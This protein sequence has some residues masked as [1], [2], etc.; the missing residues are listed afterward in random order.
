MTDISQLPVLAQITNNY[1]DYMVDE[2]P[3]G[4]SGQAYVVLSNS[5]IDPS[6]ENIIAGPAVLEASCLRSLNSREFALM[7][8][9]CIQRKSCLLRLT[10]GVQ[11][12]L[13]LARHFEGS[14]KDGEKTRE[15]GLRMWGKGFCILELPCVRPGFLDKNS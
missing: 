8:S 4:V 6:D 15:R 7:Q 9:R 13:Y 5:C 2:I 3:I 12:S 14:A 10:Q 1:S 11:Q